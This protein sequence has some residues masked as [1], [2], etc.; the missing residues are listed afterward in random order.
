MKTKLTLVICICFLTVNSFAQ[1]KGDA[2]EAYN[3]GVTMYSQLKN[4][5]SAIKS[6]E[7]AISIANQVG[8]EANDVKESA[9]SLLVSSQM[10]IATQLYSQKKYDEA[11][12][13]METAKK[14]AI[15]YNDDKNEKRI[16]SA[17]PRL[18]YAMGAQNM[19][20][21]RYNDALEDYRKSIDVNPNMSNTYLA[22]GATYQKMDSLDKALENY[23][24]TMEVAL[25]TNKPG[26]ASEARKA[27]TNYLLMKGQ[28]AKDANNFE[29]AFQYFTQAVKYDENNPDIRLQVAIA[30]NSIKKFK[31][32]IEAGEKALA[33][34]KRPNILAKVNYQLAFAYEGAGQEAKACEYYKKVPKTDSDKVNADNAIKRLMCK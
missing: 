15:E 25:R 14:T 26:D 9:Q 10:Q 34:E 23:D 1:T 4:Y 21:G 6:L 16:N 32:A 33:I 13:A 5:P 20:E 3:E 11:L 24:K 8:E 19:N 7:K 29:A 28:E 12:K 2:V 31:E 27:A 17:L 18:Y 30:G 22:M